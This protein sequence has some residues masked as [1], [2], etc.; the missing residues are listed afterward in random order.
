MCGY[1]CYNGTVIGTDKIFDSSTGTLSSSTT[2]TQSGFTYEILENR[3]GIRIE[4]QP[5]D[6][7]DS[8]V[9]PVT[10]S[11]TVYAFSGC[12]DLCGKPVAYFIPTMNAQIL[13]LIICLVQIIYVE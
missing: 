8:S 11:E 4:A 7:P 9:T 12:S 1:A 3:P 2:T 10:T 13:M 6:I 5:L